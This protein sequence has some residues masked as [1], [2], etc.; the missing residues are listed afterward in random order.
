MEWAYSME[1]GPSGEG[2]I[3][4]D[5]SNEKYSKNLEIFAPLAML[6]EV[7]LRPLQVE[8]A[9]R[10]RGVYPVAVAHLCDPDLVFLGVPQEKAHCE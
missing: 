7:L 8:V 10:Q 2:L 3:L 6:L 1:W 5:Y 4:I 9:H